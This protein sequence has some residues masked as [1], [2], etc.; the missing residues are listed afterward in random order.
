MNTKIFSYA[1]GLGFVGVLIWLYAK[2]D[3]AK[4]LGLSLGTPR[5]FSFKTSYLEF[6]EP[7]NISNPSNV[8]VNTSTIDLNTRLGGSNLGKCLLLSAVSILPKAVTELPVTVQIPY[9]DLLTAIPDF[10]NIVKTRGIKLNLYGSIYA[11]QIQLRLDKDFSFS[12]PKI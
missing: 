12:I 1:L 7:I 11:E 9:T 3:A 6:V 2:F 8:A 10:W 4:K 5:Q